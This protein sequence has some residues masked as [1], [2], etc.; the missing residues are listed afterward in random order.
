[1]SAPAVMIIGLDGAT[2]D[3]LDP[4]IAAGELPNIAALLRGGA[5]GPLRSTHPP[6]TPV[7][8]S[9]FLTG[10]NP[11]RHGIFGFMR[12]RPDYRPVF[13]NG[14]S[15][16]IPTFLDLLSEAGMRVGALNVPW[17]WPPPP[18]NRYRLHALAGSGICGRLFLARMSSAW[19][20]ADRQRPVVGRETG[21][22]HRPR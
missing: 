13:L 21:R 14:G 20:V 12:L 16:T 4:W 15:L 7:A 3:L 18:V 17:T 19:H 11:G 2:F 22:K 6:L 9:S 5:R 10:C 1:M 8:W